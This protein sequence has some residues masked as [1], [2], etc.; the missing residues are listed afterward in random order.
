MPS[1]RKFV[2]KWWL[3]CVYVLNKFVNKYAFTFI[4][5]QIYYLKSIK[6]LNFHLTYRQ[7]PLLIDYCIYFRNPVQIEKT[8]LCNKVV[9]IWLDFLLTDQIVIHLNN[10]WIAEILLNFIFHVKFLRVYLFIIIIFPVSVG[11]SLRQWLLFFDNWNYHWNKC[12]IICI[13]FFRP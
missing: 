10:I 5:S 1:V 2:Y 9:S 4:C 6:N 7:Y 11:L 12:L 3:I 8:V 13:V